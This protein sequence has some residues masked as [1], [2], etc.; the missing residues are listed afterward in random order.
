MSPRG[1]PTPHSQAP[2]VRRGSIEISNGTRPFV[3]PGTSSNAR[4]LAMVVPSH[5]TAL[6]E[7]SREERYLEYKESR[8]WNDLKTKIA[9]TA[10][11][12]A[13]IRDGGT[14][15]IGV[16]KKGTQYEPKGMR[17]KDL[18]TFDPDEIQAYINRFADPYVRVEIHQASWKGKMFDVII[19]YEFD[20][21]P[22]VCKA[23]SGDDLRQGATYT[24]SRRMPETCEV[25]SQTEMREIIEMATDKALR[26][27]V[28]RSRRVG[29]S[30]EKTIVASDSEAF[31]EQLKGL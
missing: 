3:A 28:E 17:R 30:L 23:S 31:D 26:R 27:Y 13:N 11:G 25:Q 15:I 12:M 20:E 19:V 2:G 14:I 4:D 22:V 18:A 29:I 7:L 16:A 5:I 10:M 1:W 8:P 24:R 6:I 9:R 21:I